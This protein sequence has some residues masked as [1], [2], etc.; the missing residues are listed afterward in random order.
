MITQQID[1]ATAELATYLSLAVM[2]I[3]I[4]VYLVLSLRLYRNYQKTQS[5]HSKWLCLFF[6]STPVA[7]IFL[8]LELAVLKFLT[9]D[10]VTSFQVIGSVVTANIGLDVD[11]TNALLTVDFL[12][13]LFATIAIFF[14]FISATIINIFALGFLDRKWRKTVVI[15]AI[16]SF[17]YWVFHSFGFLL[18]P[19]YQHEWS[20]EYIN[21]TWDMTYSTAAETLHIPLLVLPLAIA[22]LILFY[23]SWKVR[24]KGR[25]AFIRA[26]LIAFGLMILSTVYIFEVITPHPI[27][28]AIFR[29]GFV[30]FPLHMY[31]CLISPNWFKKLIGSPTE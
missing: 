26:F 10:G 17:L 12:G 5:A 16:L 4:V 9:P 21:G 14:S 1:D 8:I 3:A 29:L 24:V 23:V 13:W 19:D 28:T 15:P 7:I 11:T 20:Q 30:Y 22:T 6:I 31:V 18:G 25:P 2:V 27:L